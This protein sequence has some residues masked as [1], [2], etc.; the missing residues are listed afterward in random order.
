MSVLSQVG[1]PWM[2]ATD[3][4]EKLPRSLLKVSHAVVEKMRDLYPNHLNFVS[5]RHTAAQRYLRALGYTIGD[6]IPYGMHADDFHP[7]HWSRT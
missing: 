4:V 7:F 6:P 2:L 1:S 3:M 5:A